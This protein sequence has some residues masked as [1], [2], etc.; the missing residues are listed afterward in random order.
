MGFKS[1]SIRSGRESPRGSS[2]QQVSQSIL[3]FK[4]HTNLIIS[5]HR[6]VG[7]GSIMVGVG[8]ASGDRVRN[9]VMGVGRVMRVVGW[10]GL[11]VS[12]GEESGLGVGA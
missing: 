7:F 10:E 3:S 8:L 5:Q 4:L 1:T 12:I 11:V 6:E 9:L 2:N